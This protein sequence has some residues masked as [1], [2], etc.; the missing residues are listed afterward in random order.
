MSMIGQLM[1]Q[2]T[3]AYAATPQPNESTTASSLSGER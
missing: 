2:T 3:D 1:I